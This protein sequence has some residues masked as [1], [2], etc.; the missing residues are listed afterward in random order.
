MLYNEIY[1]YPINNVSYIDKYIKYNIL[2]H[3]YI[4][5]TS[6]IQ[7]AIYNIFKIALTTYYILY[8]KLTLQIMA[9]VTIV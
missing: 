9:Y 3:T 5:N 1:K 8:N 6:I 7:N 4:F 2:Y